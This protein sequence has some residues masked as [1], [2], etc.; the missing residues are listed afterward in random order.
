MARKKKHHEEGH[1]NHERWLITYADMITLLMVLFIVMFS[2]SRTDMQKYKMLK[3]SL[4][5]AFDVEV[6]TSDDAVGVMG[7]GTALLPLPSVQEAMAVPG[8]P[9][10]DPRMA[11]T[12]QD[13]REIVS[14]LPIP[15][16][17][18][19]RVEI[20]ASRDGI[21]ISLAGNVLFDSGRSDLKP[22]GLALLDAFAERLKTMPNEIRVEGHTDNVAIATALYPSNWELSSARST[23]V[24]RYL[25]EHGGLA[26]ARV[27]AAGYGEFRP[28]A[29]NDSREGRAR[30]RRVDL[31]ILF[32]QG[33]APSIAGPAADPTRSAATT[34]NTTGPATTTGTVAAERGGLR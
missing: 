16:D 6:L 8:S 15:A 33:Q 22:R 29:P 7:A 1:V 18:A 28:V 4:N 11:S 27:S 14:Q 31:V 5:R 12:L 17:S 34:A 20:G 21:V 32:P 3:A 23:T 30:N 10:Q 9:S 13:F 2:M 26:P 24:G 19:G 25:A